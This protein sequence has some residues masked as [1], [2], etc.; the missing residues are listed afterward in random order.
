MAVEIWVERNDEVATEDNTSMK[1][2]ASYPDPWE[3]TAQTLG[4]Q[5]NQVGIK[6]IK[7]KMP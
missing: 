6:R 2:P 4:N 3:P 7:D 1:A 5:E